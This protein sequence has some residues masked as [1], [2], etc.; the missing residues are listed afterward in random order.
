MIPGARVR[1]LLEEITPGKTV[2]AGTNGTVLPGGWSDVY[3]EPVV[4]VSWDG[5]TGTWRHD[6]D[7]IAV[8][9]PLQQ[10]AECSE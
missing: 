8:I 5:Y 7:E 4:L 9:P 1:L 6:E 3:G 10:L 2:P